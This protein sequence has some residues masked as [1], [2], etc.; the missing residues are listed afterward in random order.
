METSIYKPFL[1]WYFNNSPNMNNIWFYSD[2]HF[3]DTEM[4]YLRKNYIGDDEQV[5]RINS[6]VG[7]HDTIVFLGDIG[8]RS[9]IPK[10]KGGKKVL[11]K[12]NHD[13]GTSNY[14][15]LFQEI[16]EGVVAIHPKIILSHEPI[17]V[18]FAL[19]VHGHD[20]SYWKEPDGLH[21]NLCAELI[22]YTPVSINEIITSGRLRN[23]PSIHRITIDN[24]IKKSKGRGLKENNE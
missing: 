6:K 8:D 20:H 16:Y 19:N 11:V 7:K 24:A 3:N 15:G 22:D 23:I 13:T 5:K 18:P 9:F 2:P 21:L 17:D 10:I 14:T 4:K 12:G 1:N